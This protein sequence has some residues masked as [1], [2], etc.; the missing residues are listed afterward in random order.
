MGERVLIEVRRE[1][2]GARVVAVA[3]ALTQGTLDEA[4][5]ALRRHVSERGRGA[6]RVD[7]GAVEAID[8]FG[9]AMFGAVAAEAR[10]RGVDFGVTRFSPLA[11]EA[12]RQA[13]GP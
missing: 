4:R 6:V 1:A 3:G 12:F 2:D 11:A 7:L 13:P 8:N 5:H 10:R 9:V